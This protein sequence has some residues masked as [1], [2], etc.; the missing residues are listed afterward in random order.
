[1]TISASGVYRAFSLYRGCGVCPMTLMALQAEIGELDVE[2]VVVD[3]PVGAVA[4]PAV[5]RKFGVL[6]DE[7]PFLFGM[8]LRTGG[9]D[10]RLPQQ[11]FRLRPVGV[12]AVGA[13]DPLLGKGVMARQREFGLDLL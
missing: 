13:E 11:L 5:F 12:M 9:L 4:G 3:R 1:M 2:Q 7:R 8:A 6:E 10:R